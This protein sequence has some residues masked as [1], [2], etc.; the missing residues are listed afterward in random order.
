MDLSIP[1]LKYKASLNSEWQ[2]DFALK[3]GGKKIDDKRIKFPEYIA[4]GYSYFMELSPDISVHVFDLTF[5]KPTR[6]TSMP[7]D[8]NFW[9]VH[10]DMSDSCNKHFVNNIKYK[11]G[12]KSKSCFA[13][14][15]S[16]LQ[17]TYVAQGGERV[18]SLRLHIRKSFLKNQNK[19]SVIGKDFMEVFENGKRRMFYY[20]HIDSRSKVEIFNLKQQSMDNLNYEFIL[21]STAFELFGYLIERLNSNMPKPGVFL[22][23]D[24]NT[25]MKT[26]EYLLANLSG[27]FPGIKK[28]SEMAN[29]SASKYTALF[30]NV[31]GISAVSFFR[32][33][34][35]LLAKE[36]LESGKFD[37]INDVAFELDYCKTSYF[38][39][40]Y[41]KYHGELPSAVF[42]SKAH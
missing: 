33:E 34:K 16:Q 17:S 4:D 39:I 20:G 14:I 21:K 10:F 38:S 31:F 24:L 2:G 18:Y 42:K 25:L 28:L 15:D 36:L 22:Q 32:S 37:L 5:C 12:S 9:I 27:P 23:K 35:L 41:K 26:Q 13:I 30:S 1:E 40:V 7:S 19:D 29:M 3:L 6:F 8:E 11:I